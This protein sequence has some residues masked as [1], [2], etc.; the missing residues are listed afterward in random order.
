M[1]S[2]HFALPRVLVTP[3]LGCAPGTEASGETGLGKSWGNSGAMRGFSECSR[4]EDALLIQEKSPVEK[5]ATHKSWILH[6]YCTHLATLT[7]RSR[8]P[9]APGPP[10]GGGSTRERSPSDRPPSRN[11]GKPAKDAV[12]HRAKSRSQ[13]R[14][15][16]I[17][18]RPQAHRGG[19]DTRVELKA[20]RALAA[21]IQ[22]RG[23]DSA[24]APPPLG[25]RVG[26]K[27]APRAPRAPRETPAFWALRCMA[28][29]A[30]AGLLPSVLAGPRRA[31]RPPARSRPA[32]LS[33][34]LRAR[35][36]SLPLP[37]PA[38]PFLTAP[39]ANPSQEPSENK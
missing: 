8:T 39:A 27:P 6:K 11:S 30:S 37:P 20:G 3:T 17:P 23:P 38:H 34:R 22:H 35:L 29:P 33:R 4:G 16:E 18:G 15:L 26:Q 2:R 12:P 7:S 19:E 24:S 25:A 1:H 36:P 32:L 14:R 10:A 9:P 31:F 13:V 21:R 5:R 28:T